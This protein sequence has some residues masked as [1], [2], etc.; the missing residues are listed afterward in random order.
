MQP[1]KRL[2]QLEARVEALERKGLG[3][4]VSLTDRVK[5]YPLRA[6]GI[7]TTLFGFASVL[8]FLVKLHEAVEAAVALGLSATIVALPFY[9][10]HKFNEFSRKHPDWA[11]MLRGI[12]IGGLVGSMALFVRWAAGQRPELGLLLAFLFA[13]LLLSYMVLPMAERDDWYLRGRNLR[14]SIIRGERWGW[15]IIW[16]GRD[17]SDESAG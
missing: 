17:Y 7:V 3:R 15:R 14:P 11:I 10:N 9:L 6:A 16:Q 8:E 1:E 5:R 13:V 12:G 2:D 4:G